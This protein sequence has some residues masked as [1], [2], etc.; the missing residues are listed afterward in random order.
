M[1]IPDNMTLVSDDLMDRII[2]NMVSLADRYKAEL[3][4]RGATSSL[5]V[6]AEDL[7]ME[8][9]LGEDVA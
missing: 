8:F 7:I 9:I 3:A 6:V 4:E 2:L 5:V 1:D